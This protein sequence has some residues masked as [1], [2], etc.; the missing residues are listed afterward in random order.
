MP[1]KSF[2]DIAIDYK[3]RVAG[4]FILVEG[5]KLTSKVGGSDISVTRKIDGTMQVVFLRDGKAFMANSG[6]NIVEGLPCLD[7]FAAQLKKAGV[8]SA[9]VPAELY[10]PSAGSR[11]RCGDTLETLKSKDPDD[12]KKLCLA[13]F[14]LLELNGESF[15][16]TPFKEKYAKLKSLFDSD[17]VRPVEMRPAKSAA[18]VEKIFNEWVMEGGAEGIVVHSE[19]PFIWKVKPRHTL[20]AAL[21]GFTTG[22]QG[23]RDLMF[24]VRREDGMFQPFGVASNGLSDGDRQS[25]LPELQKSAVDSTYIQTDS[26]GIAY[27]MVK[28]ERVCELSV[29][30]LVSENSHGKIKWNPL[31]VLKE[32]GWICEGQTPG[33]SALGMTVV[34]GRD[35]KTPE[36]TAIRVS[37]LSDI[38]PFAEAKETGKGSP[39]EL[40][41][42]RVFKKVS[43]AKSMV[44]KFVIWKTNKEETGIYPAYVFHYTDYSA[45]RKEALKRDLRVSSSEEQIRKIMDDFIAENIK[46]GWEEVL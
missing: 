30:E 19:L 33:V 39:S 24:A 6:G 10:V 40:L 14:D 21:I 41:A 16:T 28:P 22:D 45:S 7:D 9:S 4:A 15:Q 5:D 3:H 38:C 27:Q 43:G 36:P 20:D 8:T 2:S 29:S 18:E 42:R 34:R 32:D 11:P 23:I 25:L 1:D 35:D 44:Q 46:K 37:Q 17:H 31:L 13:P 12:A 26:R